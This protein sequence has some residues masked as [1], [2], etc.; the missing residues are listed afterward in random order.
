MILEKRPD[1]FDR[2]AEGSSRTWLI[3]LG[4]GGGQSDH[5]S[6]GIDER[7][8]NDAARAS[9][10][11][12]KDARQHVQCDHFSWSSRSSAPANGR[13]DDRLSTDRGNSIRECHWLRGQ[14]VAPKECDA[15]SL[16]S[17]DHLG[18]PVDR[19]FSR[20]VNHQ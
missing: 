20:R 16:R 7:G 1:P 17:G 2:S 18:R 9:G 10:S 3:E 13:H 4:R 14:P 11:V 8:T 5:S 6:S 12:H 19:G 15:Q